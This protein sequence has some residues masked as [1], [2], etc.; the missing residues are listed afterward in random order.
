M[1]MKGRSEVLENGSFDVNKLMQRL[2]TKHGSLADR[3]AEFFNRKAE[4]A[5]EYG[6]V[7]ADLT[8]KEELLLPLKLHT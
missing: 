8:S 7:V 5:K 6:L 4:I 2:K 3:E 1:A